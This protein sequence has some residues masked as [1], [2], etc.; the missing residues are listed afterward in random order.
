LALA[1]SRGPFW[2]SSSYQT[3]FRGMNVPPLAYATS[4]PCWNEAEGKASIESAGA[5]SASPTIRSSLGR[6]ARPLYSARVIRP[7][8]RAGAAIGAD[9]TFG[10]GT[11]RVASERVARSCG[12]LSSASPWPVM[13][14]AERSLR[15]VLPY[16][17]LPSVSCP[18]SVRVSYPESGLVTSLCLL[19]DGFS[20]SVRNC[21]CADGR[22]RED[23]FSIHD[24]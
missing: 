5:P 4:N 9:F 12:S 24:W 10:M 11:G 16:A 3:T 20:R 19:T 21:C 8:T 15:F 18:S 1:C 22:R 6:D 13:R 14:I 17:P 2:G 7:W 23:G